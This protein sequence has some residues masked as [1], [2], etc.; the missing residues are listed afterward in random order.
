V[1]KVPMASSM[2]CFRR[3]SSLHAQR[4][5]TVVEAVAI[6]N[7]TGPCDLCTKTRAPPAVFLPLTIHRR[8]Q[9]RSYSARYSSAGFGASPHRQSSDDHKNLWT[10]RGAAS[11]LDHGTVH[12]HRHRQPQ[13]PPQHTR[14]RSTLGVRQR[15]KRIGQRRPQHLGQFG[16]HPLGHGYPPLTCQVVMIGGAAASRISAGFFTSHGASPGHSGLG[17]IECAVE[18]GPGHPQRGADR[19]HRLSSLPH[20]VS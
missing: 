16:T 15:Q 4:Y 19:G 3:W 12:R 14:D 9:P 20:P 8:R 2:A 6:N 17:V 11:R 10:S 7:F 18:S 13:D 5:R 1:T